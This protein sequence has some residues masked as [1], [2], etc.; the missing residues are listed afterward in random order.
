[1]LTLDFEISD[2]ARTRFA[3]S[4]IFEAIASL[5]LVRDPSQAGP[6]VPW[7]RRTIE[8]ARG[9]DLD[10]LLALTPTD[11]YIPDFLTPPPMSPVASFEEE[12]Q[13]V[14]ATSGDIIR[15]DLAILFEGEPVP[16]AAADLLMRP[17]RTLSRL[18]S[19]LE[20][21]WHRALKPDWPRV[22]SLLDADLAHR[23]RRLTEGG[24]ASLFVDLNHAARWRDGRLEITCDYEGR[25]AL[26][27][28][29]LLIAP[30][31][32]YWQSVGP[33]IFPPWQPTLFYPA[34]GL[35]L[36]W[37]PGAPVPHALE[38][39]VG[40]SRAKLLTA[41]DV[42]RSTTDV[43]RQLGLSA[44]AVSQHLSVLRAAGLVTSRRR[45]REVLYLRTT[46]AEHLQAPAEVTSRGL[47]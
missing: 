12:L 23:A 30:S 10:L 7:L 32:F 36:L 44:A 26:G 18:T 6:H 39:V 24:P 33:L 4:P 2:L 1:M 34:R 35:E 3:I 17:R 9:M 11:S 25:A 13:R 16:A 46:L 31:A 21:W 28:R 8:V 15:H 47:V 43:A 27:G 29:G 42:P 37:A 38:R 41:L 45:G 5:R 22:R 14:R 20:E 40:R 19:A